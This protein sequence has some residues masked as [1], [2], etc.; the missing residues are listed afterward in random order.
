MTDKAAVVGRMLQLWERYD[1]RVMTSENITFLRFCFA[2]YIN[3]V[4]EIL[5]DIY[6]VVIRITVGTK[7][8]T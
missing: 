2:Q 1:I 6:V 5:R 8:F 3:A 7:I 4:N